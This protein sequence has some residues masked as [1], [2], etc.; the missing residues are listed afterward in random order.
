M[1]GR[2]IVSD[3][4]Y[5]ARIMGDDGRAVLWIFP[6]YT[7]LPLL[8]IGGLG[9]PGVY[10]NHEGT[11]CDGDGGCP[12]GPEGEFGWVIDMAL[13]SGWSWQRPEPKEVAS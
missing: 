10:V 11:R 1:T 7:L 8:R 9:V 2:M 6:S 12:R 3:D 13:E 5:S 4:G